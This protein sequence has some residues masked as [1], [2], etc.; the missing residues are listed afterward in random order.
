MNTVKGNGNASPQQKKK[1]KKKTLD[2]LSGVCY[3]KYIRK[4]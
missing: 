4:R 3:N 2:K 1:I